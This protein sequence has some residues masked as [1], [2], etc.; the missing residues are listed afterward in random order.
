MKEF[1]R[2]GGAL[3]TVAAFGLGAAVGSIIALLYAPASGKV[4]RRRLVLKVRTMRRTAIRKLGD[5]QRA[6]ATGAVRVRDAASGWISDRMNGKAHPIRHRTA[7]HAHA[8]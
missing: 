6:L 2:R 8:N 7:R 4:T 3:R 5:T 1:R